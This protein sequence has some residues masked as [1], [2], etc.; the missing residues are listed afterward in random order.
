MQAL[1]QG[2]KECDSLTC[3]A[4]YAELAAAL[5][6]PDTAAREL[7]SDTFARAYDQ[8]PHDT[9]DEVVEKDPW[10]LL[11]LPSGTAEVH[12]PQTC[13]DA[14]KLECF[15]PC[16]DADRHRAGPNSGGRLEIGS[17][18]HAMSPIAPVIFA[19][20]QETK[21]RVTCAVAIKRAQ[22]ALKDATG[23]PGFHQKV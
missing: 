3:A 5:H 10:L 8:W 9:A 12:I 14:S 4:H 17:R 20:L 22:K 15:Q 18:F 6:F 1:L 16:H 7:S 13:N 23:A 2:A 11:N 19:V 21:R